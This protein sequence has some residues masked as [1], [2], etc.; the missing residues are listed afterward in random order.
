MSCSP[1]DDAE[2]SH[3]FKDIVFVLL[4][5]IDSGLVGS[6]RHRR[7]FSLSV[8]HGIGVNVSG[9]QSITIAEMHPSN[10]GQGQVRRNP[11]KI[12]RPYT[13]VVHDVK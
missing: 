10:A 6:V 7:L 11:C 2:P 13:A 9:R 3:G 12:A 5:A 8:R 4:Q 1:R